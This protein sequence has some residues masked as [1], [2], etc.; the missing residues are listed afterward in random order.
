MNEVPD[1]Y[2]EQMKST[3]EFWGNNCGGCEECS[4]V[5]GDRTSPE[6]DMETIY[7][8]II[9]LQ[10]RRKPWWEKLWNAFRSVWAG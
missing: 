3:I 4:R 5:F 9:E 1:K 2:L 7:R 6:F 10:E 8:L